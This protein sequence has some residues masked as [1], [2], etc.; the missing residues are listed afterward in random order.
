MSCEGSPGARS[1]WC[2][3]VSTRTVWIAS[4]RTGDPRPRA[5]GFHVVSIG[6]LDR[7]KRPQTL[8]QAFALM[9]GDSGSVDLHRRRTDET[10][11]ARR[12]PAFRPRVAGRGDGGRGPRGRLS[13][14]LA[15]GPVR[16]RL[17]SRGSS[18]RGPRGDGMRQSPWWSRTSIRIA[19]SWPG[20]PSHGWSHPET[21]PVSPASSQPRPSDAVGCTPDR[22]PPGAGGSW[23]GGST[24]RRCTEGTAACTSGCGGGLGRGATLSLPGRGA[25]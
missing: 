11:C 7:R 23:S 19:R 15:R 18:H 6:R 2:P 21:S 5:T 13:D 24:L 12:S 10:R 14:A 8:V 1:S 20:R 25:R 4:S 9:A 16:V 22:R 3:T 17:A